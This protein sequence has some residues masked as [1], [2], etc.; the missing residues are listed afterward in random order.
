[1]TRRCSFQ[2]FKNFIG[3]L[4]LEIGW[5]LIGSIYLTIGF[6]LLAVL[7]DGLRLGI[8]SDASAYFCVSMIIG[9]FFACAAI[10]ASKELIEGS[11]EV[12]RSRN[13]FQ[14]SVKQKYFIKRCSAKSSQ[15]CGWQCLR[16]SFLYFYWF[17]LE[18]CMDSLI[19]LIVRHVWGRRKPID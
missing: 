11:R 18:H 3:V 16:A 19:A 14:K 4:S 13:I 8:E 2:K 7:A 10:H 6:I 5:K 12:R 15:Q 1:M 17:L 9:I